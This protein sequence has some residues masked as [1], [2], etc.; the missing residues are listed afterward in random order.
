MRVGRLVYV[1]V[2][3][4]LVAVLPPHRLQPTWRVDAGVVHFMVSDKARLEVPAM[5]LIGN[6]LS[7]ATELERIV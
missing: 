6:L 5:A 4:L 2:W 7:Y 3:V 1:C